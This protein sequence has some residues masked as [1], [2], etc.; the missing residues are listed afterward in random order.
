[1]LAQHCQLHYD[2][3]L[4]DSRDALQKVGLAK[5]GPCICAHLLFQLICMRV[6]QVAASA[7]DTNPNKVVKL[8][9]SF[10]A[11]IAFFIW[12]GLR[13]TPIPNAAGL[14]INWQTDSETLVTIIRDIHAYGRMASVAT[15]QDQLLV[16]NKIVSTASTQLLA[17]D[18]CPV[19]VMMTACHPQQCLRHILEG[20]KRASTFEVSLQ[21]T[22]ST[23]PC[24]TAPGPITYNV[25]LHTALLLLK[26]AS[27][28]DSI[29]MDC[30]DTSLPLRVLWESIQGLSVSI[31]QY[32]DK[33]S[34]SNSTKPYD[35]LMSLPKIRFEPVEERHLSRLLVILAMPM[36]EQTITHSGPVADACLCL[37]LALMANTKTAT[38]RTVAAQ[39]MRTGQWFSA[40]DLAYVTCI[41]P[42]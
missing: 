1:L 35:I 26:L 3:E 40:V 25:L 15:E 12:H 30:P 7:L 36:L 38:Y 32:T 9:V 14:S 21:Q 17:Q 42:A 28:A 5:P 10:Q 20:F 8:G 2:H 16:Y 4:L 23:G 24:P 18:W 41:K 19:L 27:L 29:T 33:P 22:M 34:N 11:S 39:I 31:S 13:T 37:L 6:V